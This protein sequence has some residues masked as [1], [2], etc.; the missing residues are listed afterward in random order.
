MALASIGLAW[1]CEL[2]LPKLIMGDE[3]KLSV[4]ILTI[5]NIGNRHRA[6][7]HIWNVS[8]SDFHSFLK[9]GALSSVASNTGIS[10][11]TRG[12]IQY[13]SELLYY[14]AAFTT[15]ASILFLIAR[16]FAPHRK[17]VLIV[18]VMISV[19]VLYYL[20]AFFIKLFRCNPIRKAWVPGIDGNCIVTEY[21]MLFAD[22]IVSIITDLGILL[23]P[24]PLVWMLQTS[25]RRKLRVLSVFAAGIVYVRSVPTMPRY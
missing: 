25:L 11:L 20:P 14:W 16:V 15:K 19:M 21:S 22:C 23:I 3:R 10:G 5:L 17:A 1:S 4:P 9:V 7:E 12:Q 2:A 8:E 13:F 24:L 6:G 18:R